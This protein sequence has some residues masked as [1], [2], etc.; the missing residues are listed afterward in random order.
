MK[1]A[2]KKIE[3]V[4]EFAVWN[5]LE[6]AELFSQEPASRLRSPQVCSQG[7][8][9]LRA[10]HHPAAARGDRRADD[11][12]PFT[13]DPATALVTPNTVRNQLKAAFAKTGA[14]RQSELA[15]LLS[16]L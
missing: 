2:Q 4:D 10:R 5:F 1:F 14:H 13:S 7:R 16:R 15:A 8:H 12:P 11:L 9:E 3:C 6:P